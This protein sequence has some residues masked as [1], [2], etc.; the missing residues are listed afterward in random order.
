V[1]KDVRL[2]VGNDSAFHSLFIEDPRGSNSHKLSYHEITCC[3]IDFHPDKR[4]VACGD[5]GCN[6][7]VWDLEKSAPV[8]NT[9]VGMSVR[10]LVWKPDGRSIQIA[11]LVS[12]L[13]S[14][15]VTEGRKKEGERK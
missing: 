13:V 9:V 3:G 1:E 2:L 7:Y 12:F 6:V 4:L 8:A 14:L 11:C 5:F 10:A 15:F